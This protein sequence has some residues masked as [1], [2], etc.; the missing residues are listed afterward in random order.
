MNPFRQRILWNLVGPLEEAV[1]G[2]IVAR[3]IAQ[4]V[5]LGIGQNVQAKYSHGVTSDPPFLHAPVG[6][7]QWAGIR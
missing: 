5:Q 3:L 4:F 7:M 1:L 2:P 6:S